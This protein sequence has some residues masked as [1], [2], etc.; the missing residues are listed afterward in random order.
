MIRIGLGLEFVLA[1]INSLI[2]S[3][4]CNNT[5]SLLCVYVEEV[6]CLPA[7]PSKVHCPSKDSSKDVCFKTDMS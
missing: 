2:D 7:V 4:T 5:C 6:V 1:A 3:L